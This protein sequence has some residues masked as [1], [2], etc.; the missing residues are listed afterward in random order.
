M[1]PQ[2][3]TRALILFWEDFAPILEGNLKC[4]S[5][6]MESVYGHENVWAVCLIYI[7]LID[8]TSEHFAFFA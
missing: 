4:N 3:A 7:E 5:K 6:D 1:F 8:Y 2:M